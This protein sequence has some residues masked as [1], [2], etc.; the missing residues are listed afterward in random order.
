[1]HGVETEAQMRERIRATSCPP[2]LGRPDLSL[3][4]YSDLSISLAPSGAPALEHPKISIST[5]LHV[6]PAFSTEI[7]Q[8]REMLEHTAHFQKFHVGK[9]QPLTPRLEREMARERMY[10]GLSSCEKM[11]LAGR[12]VYV[13]PKEE[14]SSPQQS[15]IKLGTLDTSQ[16]RTA[17]M[18]QTHAMM[19]SE[20]VSV[21][22][23]Q[24]PC[25]CMHVLG[26]LLKIAYSGLQ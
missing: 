19:L 2:M 1:M 5:H 17:A 14:E 15:K 11:L 26:N 12:D 21:C 20:Q 13:L 23:R 8:A 16:L 10:K 25:A 7:R 3:L 6:P 9:I 18:I 4:T 24:C 22:M